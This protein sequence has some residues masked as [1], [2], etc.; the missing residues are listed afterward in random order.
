[1]V[2]VGGRAL[3]RAAPLIRTAAWHAPE[4]PDPLTITERRV[5]GDAPDE[6]DAAKLRAL[7]ERSGA[8][9]ALRERPFAGHAAR[10][11][12][13]IRV[14][15]DLAAAVAAI[16]DPSDQVSAWFD[17]HRAPDAVAFAVAVAVMEGS[18]Y[19][20]VADAAVELRVALSSPD[21]RP[22][23]I[24][25]LDRLADEQP[26]L[27]LVP[28]AL[29]AGPPR[30]RFRSP[31][32]GQT[33][34]AHAWTT[35][36]SH[37]DALLG[38]LRRLL[39][40]PDLEVRARAAV[41]AGGVTLTDQAAEHRFLTSWATNTRWPVRQAAAT[42][43]GVAG[44]RPETSEIVWELLQGWAHAGS[45]ARERRLAGT[46][47]TAAGGLLGRTHPARALD[48]LRDALDRGDDWGTLIPVAWAGV[49]LINQGQ[50]A[51]V[52][53]AYLDWSRPRDQSPLVLRALTAFVF[54]TTRPYTDVGAVSPVADAVP[55][56]PLLLTALPRHLPPL[57]DSGRVPWPASPYRTG[58]WMPSRCCSTITSPGI[59]K[60]CPGY[61]T[62]RPATPR[63]RTVGT[64]NAFGTGSRAGPPTGTL[65]RATPRSCTT[66]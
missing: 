61:E 12:S 40:H 43:L 23:D 30:V 56:V 35:L 9:V 54:A 3:A 27:E 49:H 34:L 51:H 46:A 2:L 38:W 13:V 31:L 26:W 48:L 4:P 44:S 18:S 20:T 50:V 45:T 15:G 29:A 7:L 10:L 57:R 37:R 42:A 64:A 14:D 32:I 11:A 59:P 62:L 25:F 66:P 58:R 1:M 17:H 21:D 19:L 63:R 24:R 65:P 16:R 5:L 6:D 22:P 36:D 39:T 47:A 55:G 41:A 52:L 33:V 53:D 8:A 28:D 60:H